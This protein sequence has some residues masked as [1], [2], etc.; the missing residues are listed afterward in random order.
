[1]EV[2]PC[3]HQTSSPN[4]SA[5]RLVAAAKTTHSELGEIVLDLHTAQRRLARLR[6]ALGY[7]VTMYDSGAVTEL[8]DDTEP[9]D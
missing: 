8:P 9:R 2:R 4:P 7:A 3:R 6:S 5:D 1:M